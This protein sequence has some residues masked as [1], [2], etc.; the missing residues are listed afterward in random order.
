MDIYHIWFD[1]K[2]GTDERAFVAALRAFLNRLKGDGQIES[3]RLMRCKLGLRPDTVREFDVMIETRDLAQLDEAF[4][5]AA[6]RK[7]PVD[8][9]HFAANAMVTNVKF[10]LFRD[11]PDWG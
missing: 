6:S 5:V 7:G 2:P 3:W 9:M 4:R 1:L 11:W 10:G 8:E